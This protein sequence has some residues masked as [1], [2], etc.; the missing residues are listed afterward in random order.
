[1]ST[2]TDRI[3]REVENTRAQVEETV[4]ALREK[5]SLGQMVDE[6]ARYFQSSGGGE[7]VSNLGTQVR[8]NPI[9]L[10]LVGVGLAWLM[11]GRGQPNMEIP[12]VGFRHDGS[13][14]EPRYDPRYPPG[15]AY[16]S[17]EAGIRGNGHER[18]SW[19]AG[20]GSA[21]GGTASGMA[22]SAESAA[23]RAGEA[24]HSAA[25]RAGEGASSA[26]HRAG[27]AAYRVGEAVSSAAGSAAGGVYHAG[28]AAASGARSMAEGAL[29]GGRYAGEAAYGAYDWG[30][31]N[32]AWI[33]GRA[34]RTF[35]RMLDEEPLAIGALGLAVGA[36][37]GAMLPPTEMEDEYF[38]ETRDSWKRSA[39]DYAREQLDHGVEMAE[40]AYAAAKDEFRSEDSGTTFAE[41]AEHA[42][43]A[44]AEKVKGEDSEAGTSSAGSTPGSASS[45]GSSAPA[46][47]GLG[48]SF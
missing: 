2:E 20:E 37:I 13:R 1:M 27:D 31:R 15:S 35:A 29:S 36:A 6:A 18:R 14:H 33:G 22:S 19:P 28:S 34:R 23:H 16:G 7:M 10:L 39:E 44:A 5:L 12:H 46:R 42:V 30:S 25:Q 43:K 21:M 3:E 48:T 41:R 24:A 40:E 8:A 9:P 47:N 4:D 26:M 11:S 38:G 32:A 45:E 17:S